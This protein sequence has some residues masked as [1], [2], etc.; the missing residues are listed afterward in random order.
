MPRKSLELLGG[1][2]VK[3]SFDSNVYLEDQEPIRPWTAAK[4]LGS[5]RS[6][7][8]G[9]F[10]PVR[11]ARVGVGFQKSPIFRSSLSY[12]PEIVRY[13]SARSEE[14]CGPPGGAQSRRPWGKVSADLMNSLIYIDGSTLG[15]TFARPD[16]V[17]R[18][19]AV[20][21]WR[22]RREAFLFRTPS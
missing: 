15:P 7:Q 8:E 1:A 9:V 16:D 2:T 17:T 12:A 19:S 10:C 22:D 13:H 18:R 6:L 14:P 4:A 3:E 5:A 20:F 11:H 21:H